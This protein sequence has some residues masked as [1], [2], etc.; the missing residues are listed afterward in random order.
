[1]EENRRPIAVFDSGVGG[2]SVLRA[3]V[4]LMPYENYIYFGDSAHAPYGSKTLEEV[5]ALT[6]MHVTHLLEAGAKAV[7]VACNTATSADISILRERYPHIPMI[8][9]E[10]AVKPAVES[11]KRPG[12]LVMATPMTLQQEKFQTLLRRYEMQADIYPLPCPGLVEYVERGE[13]SGLALENFLE[14]ML[15]PYR[16]PVV[17]CV[18]LGCTHYPFVAGTIQKLLG[19]VKVFEG[20]PGTARETR[21]RLAECGLLNPSQ[22]KGW[23]R[24]E[25]SLEIPG[26]LELCKKLLNSKQFLN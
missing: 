23:V 18:V 9:I 7:V 2:I 22:E 24:F 16:F 19:D 3:L 4:D 10:P 26:E 5:R 6:E 1:M 20:G 21:R 17:D 11:G 13:L 12:V 25:N 14:P 8:G 15:A